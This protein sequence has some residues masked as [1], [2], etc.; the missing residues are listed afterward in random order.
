MGSS[1]IMY[2]LRIDCSFNFLIKLSLKELWSNIQAGLFPLEGILCLISNILNASFMDT[3]CFVLLMRSPSLL[4]L[5]HHPHALNQT[6]FLSYQAD[7]YCHFIISQDYFLACKLMTKQSYIFLKVNIQ[8]LPK[9][10]VFF[11]ICLGV[12]KRKNGRRSKEGMAALLLSC[13]HFS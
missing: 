9:L 12:K 10:L 4:P 1:N 11:Q 13:K 6:T 7:L 3:S 8:Y 2:L 5:H